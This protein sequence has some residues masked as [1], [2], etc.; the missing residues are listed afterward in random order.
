VCYSYGLSANNIEIS[1]NGRIKNP[2]C[3]G[4]LENDPGSE[5]RKSGRRCSAATNHGNPEPAAYQ[6]SAGRPMLISPCS[7][8]T[9]I[10]SLFLGSE[11][12]AR[13]SW[14]FGRSESPHVATA[15]VSRRRVFF[16]QFSGVRLAL[17]LALVRLSYRADNQA[18]GR[19]P[20]RV[21]GFHRDA[22]DSTLKLSI[23]RADEGFRATV[24]GAT[25]AR[26]LCVAHH[27]SFSRTNA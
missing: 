2:K 9:E 7:L 12:D 27:R 4:S 11:T 16:E 14:R 24:D 26:P 3:R 17:D 22:A 5:D 6:I 1:R 23:S 8:Y 10:A 19:H 20:S 18:I 25:F 21:P 15:V 13:R